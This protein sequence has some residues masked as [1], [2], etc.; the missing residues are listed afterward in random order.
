M[1]SNRPVEEWSRSGR[2]DISPPPVGPLSL[3]SRAAPPTREVADAHVGAEAVSARILLSPSYKE[4]SQSEVSTEPG[5]FG[6]TI[7]AFNKPRP[8]W[9]CQVQ[10]RTARFDQTDQTVQRGSL[11]RRRRETGCDVVKAARPAKLDERQGCS[12]LSRTYFGEAMSEDSDRFRMRARQY[13]ELAR[14]ARDEHSREALDR[15]AIEL[16]EEADQI[17]AEAANLNKDP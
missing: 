1:M 9:S 7:M 6:P 10:K 13:R 5:S 12:R 15:M 14:M 11:E 2:P 8:S 4:E 3:Y 16:D 17:E